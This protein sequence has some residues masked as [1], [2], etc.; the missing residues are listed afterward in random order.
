MPA[1]FLFIDSLTVARSFGAALTLSTVTIA[2]SSV[3]HH[4]MALGMAIA[5]T[6]GILITVSILSPSSTKA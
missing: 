2:I 4:P 5:L 3:F 1:L 6:V